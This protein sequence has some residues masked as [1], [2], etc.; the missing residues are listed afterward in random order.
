MDIPDYRQLR[1][2]N[3]DK[4]DSGLYMCDI[5]YGASSAIRRNIM[6]YVITVDTTTSHSTAS[7]LMMTEDHSSV[8]KNYT[9]F[10]YTAGSTVEYSGKRFNPVL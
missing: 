2:N 8:Q 1:I 7:T 6:V 4:E 9:V 3:T 5:Y 10:L